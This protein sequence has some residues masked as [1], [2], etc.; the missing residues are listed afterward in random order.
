MRLFP[1]AIVPRKLVRH[2]WPGSLQLHVFAIVLLAVLP[3]GALQL[4]N[5]G[6]E[7]DRILARTHEQ[8][9]RIA[10]Q[11]VNTAVDAVHEAR[12]SLQ[13]LSE[14]PTLRY[15]FDES[16]SIQLMK[17]VHAR[18]W[19]TGLFALDPTGTVVCASDPQTMGISIADRSYVKTALERRSFFAGDFI[20][21]RKSRIPMIGSALPV[22]SSD[23][24]LIR[25]FIA[26]IATTWF[27][28]VA[29]DLVQAN[30]GSTV[31]LVDGNGIV[32]ADAPVGGNQIGK[33]LASLQMRAALDGLP[34]DNFTAVGD[35][36][37]ERLF[38]SASLS[39]SRA[40][41]L[42]GMSR[43]AVL[44]DLAAKRK[45]ALIE[46][47]ALML[48]LGASVWALCAFAISRP[49]RSLL[50][51][52]TRVGEGRLTSRIAAYHWPRELAALARTSNI[53]AARLNRR[54]AELQQ[55]HAALEKQSLTDHLTGLPNRR[56]FDVMVDTAWKQSAIAG[57]PVSLC[58]IDAD[59]F[60][61]YN[62]LYG[63]AAGDDALR[64]IADVLARIASAHDGVAARVGGE[65]FALL[66]E[67]FDETA[68]LHV[69]C[70]IMHANSK[71]DV[72][73]VSVG[74]ASA[75][76]VADGSITPVFAAADAALYAAKASGRN[77]A[78]G[79]SRLGRLMPQESRQD[80][81]SADASSRA[82]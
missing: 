20:I 27:D 46:L 4:R 59:H 50:Q 68:A 44:T 12:S 8:A 16:C 34:Q 74:A 45:S 52:A 80:A 13:L 2:I 53:M 33:P 56:C 81:R 49:I 64:A 31:T 21:G 61:L 51:H 60:K 39:H 26:T 42:V 19:A 10:Q 37:I 67:G 77:C 58:M 35:D 17:I 15:G 24:E 11:A 62:D 29:A 7:Q 55:A 54:N 5:F 30:P 6:I 69:S 40:R 48:L 22:Y 79:A 71:H 72:V 23:G 3:I 57:E 25:I 14:V 28:K 18:P 9:G 41:L 73:S 43:D 66:L 75:I 76:P 1:S 38:G 36:G 70:S 82:A 63:H 78:I 65:E 32:L 47:G